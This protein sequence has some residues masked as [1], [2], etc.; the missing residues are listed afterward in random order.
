MNWKEVELEVKS[1]RKFEVAEE[2]AGW[3]P[4]QSKRGPK[5]S[6]PP[7]PKAPAMQPDKKLRMGNKMYMLF[8]HLMSYLL[9]GNPIDS[10]YLYSLS[11]ILDE[12]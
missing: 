5:T 2:T 7:I 9:K 11:I 12:K 4:S 1:T 6:P 8:F 10:L 3:S